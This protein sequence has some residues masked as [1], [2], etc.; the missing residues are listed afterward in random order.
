MVCVFVFLEQF[1]DK[2][3]TRDS[4]N[5]ILNYYDLSITSELNHVNWPTLENERNIQR[6]NA[7]YIYHRFQYV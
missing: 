5:K 2:I 1:F 4:K 7:L 3:P 6:H